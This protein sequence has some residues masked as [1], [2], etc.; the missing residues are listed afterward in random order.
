[1]GCKCWLPLVWREHWVQAELESAGM[2]VG[3][4]ASPSG[5]STGTTGVHLPSCLHVRDAEESLCSSNSDVFM[6][7]P[8]DLEK[9]A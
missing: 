1:M 9:S 7:V 5:E 3:G 2:D 8:L 4:G 6:M